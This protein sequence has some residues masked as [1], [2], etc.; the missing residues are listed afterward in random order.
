MKALID[1]VVTFQSFNTVRT[2]VCGNKT[3]SNSDILSAKVEKNHNDN[4][5]LRDLLGTTKQ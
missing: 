3:W 5:L 4:C 2:K 1:C